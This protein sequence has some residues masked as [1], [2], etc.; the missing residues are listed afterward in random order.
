M[1]T[2]KKGFPLQV[3]ED[4]ADGVYSNV[5]VVRHSGLEFVLDFAHATPERPQPRLVS[6]VTVSPQHAKTLLRALRTNIERY[7]KSYG[8]IRLPAGGPG[9]G[10]KPT[11]GSA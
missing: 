9:W 8:E 10:G 2:E 1:A 3:P 11:A 5:A 6:R 7:E 4:R